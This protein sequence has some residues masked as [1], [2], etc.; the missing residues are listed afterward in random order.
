MR[1]ARFPGHQIIIAVLQSVETGLT[2][3]DVCCEV[4]SS[5]ASS[6]NRKVNYG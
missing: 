6:C 4:G 2:V 1:N 3:K 5:E